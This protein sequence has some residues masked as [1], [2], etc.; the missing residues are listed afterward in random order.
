M[1]SQQKIVSGSEQNGSD[2]QPRSR[3]Q[4]QS[5][6]QKF[7]RIRTSRTLSV[8]GPNWVW[9]FWRMRLC[10]LQLTLIGINWTLIRVQTSR[11]QRG[12]VKAAEP[13]LTQPNRTG[14]GSVQSAELPQIQTSLCSSHT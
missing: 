13:N 3:R 10:H 1:L 6:I 4:N 8:T 14:P 5:D 7:F 12:K 2:L 9:W 11:T